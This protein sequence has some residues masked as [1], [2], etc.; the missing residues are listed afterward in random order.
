MT[1]KHSESVLSTPNDIPFV[2]CAPNSQLFVYNDEANMEFPYVSQVNDARLEDGFQYICYITNGGVTERDAPEFIS[3]DEIHLPSD[4]TGYFSGK[5][6]KQDAKT[7]SQESVISVSSDSGTVKVPTD[8][9]D[10]VVFVTMYNSAKTTS[11]T[12]TATSGITLP[13]DTTSTQSKVIRRRRRKKN[14]V[15]TP[16]R[17]P[18]RVAQMEKASVDLAMKLS[19]PPAIFNTKIPRYGCANVV[20]STRLL[21]KN[22]NCQF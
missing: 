12:T 4:Y 14:G 15:V 20:V 16:R 11:T 17:N 13:E 3:V 7:E 1:T 8:S 21:G 6:A 2:E 5:E 18:K 22:R 10:D 9:D 19:L